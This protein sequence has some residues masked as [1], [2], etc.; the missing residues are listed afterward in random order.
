MFKSQS[1]FFLDSTFNRKDLL[2]FAH[3]KVF[4]IR[5]IFNIIF[6]HIDMLTFMHSQ[7]NIYIH[8]YVFYINIEVIFLQVY[9]HID[10]YIYIYMRI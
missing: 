1:V 4:M 3:V 10:I 9:I 2:T 5:L 7:I 8:V 6:L